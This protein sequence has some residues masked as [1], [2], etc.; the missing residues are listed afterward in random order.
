MNYHTILQDRYFKL[1]G[2]PAI[3]CFLG[4]IS[5]VHTGGSLHSWS[6]FGKW[7]GYDDSAGVV[8]FLCLCNHW[9]KAAFSALLLHKDLKTAGGQGAPER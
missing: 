3:A 7:E 2:F 1:L 5:L 9:H 4:E 8:H 6:A